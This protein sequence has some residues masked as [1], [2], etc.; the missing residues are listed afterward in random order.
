MSLTIEG[1]KYVLF[2]RSQL[3]PLC[4]VIRSRLE[5]GAVTVEVRHWVPMK[6]RRQR[7]FLHALIRDLAQQLNCDERLLK[8][9]LKAAL[10]VVVVEPSLVTGDREARVVPTEVYT[11]EQY[12]ALIYAIQAW[13]ALK[14]LRALQA[15]DHALSEELMRHRA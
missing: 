9:D 12:T 1:H 3:V 4:D 14:G 6:T 15:D 7:D 2:N 11:R 8:A 10:G 5:H 13:A